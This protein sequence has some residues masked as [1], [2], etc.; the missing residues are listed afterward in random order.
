MRQIGFAIAIVATLSLFLY[1]ESFAQ[2]GIGMHS[3][4]GWGAEQYYRKEIKVYK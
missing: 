3:S 4:G 2:P 1:H